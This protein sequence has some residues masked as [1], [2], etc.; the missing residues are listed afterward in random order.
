MRELGRRRHVRF[1]P[2]RGRG[3]DIP[4]RQLRANRV[5]LIV[6]PAPSGLPR[7]TDILGVRQHV[8]KVPTADLDE[9]S[10][11]PEF[12]LIRQLQ[13]AAGPYI[14]VKTRN[15]RCEQM[16]TALPPTTDILAG[17]LRGSAI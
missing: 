2:G 6:G 11:N 3:A 15:T 8:S 12:T 16:F 13:R 7:S 9:I 14:R 5:T 10:T 4:V 17:L 1:V